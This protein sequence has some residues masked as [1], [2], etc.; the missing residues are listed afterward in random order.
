MKSLNIRLRGLVVGL[1]LF[2]CISASAVTN[3]LVITSITRQNN[4]TTLTWNSHSAEFY[5]VQW[6]DNLTPPIFWRVAEVNV[7]SQGTNTVWS[8]GGCGQMLMAGVGG[9]SESVSEPAESAD[10]SKQAED[11]PAVP[12]VLP[13]D[14]AKQLLPLAIYPPGIDLTGY[15]IIWPDGSTE[16]WSEEIVEKWRESQRGNGP[17]TDGGEDEGLAVEARF[18]RIVRTAVVGTVDGWSSAPMDIPRI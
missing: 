7:P 17:E 5:T 10:D 3:D 14:D 15:T 18:Y 1:A 8:E 12:M 6:T 11:K 2:V 9:G 16:E 4:C 13:K